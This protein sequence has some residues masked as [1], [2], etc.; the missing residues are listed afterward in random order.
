MVFLLHKMVH[1][2]LEGD[3]IGEDSLRVLRTD[4]T[5]G[6]CCVGGRR[7]QLRQQESSLGTSCITNNEA[8]EGE[9][10]RNEVLRKISKI[11]VKGGVRSTHPSV[12]FRLLKKRGKVLVS[13]LFLITGFSP[14]CNGLAMEDQNVEEGIQE[15]NVSGLDR[16]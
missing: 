5:E 7:V 12:F 10:V 16:C 1:K 15:K 14:L 4:P 3:I 9:S 13:F 2:C 8:R 6:S 11:S